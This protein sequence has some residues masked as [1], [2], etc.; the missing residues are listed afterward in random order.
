MNTKYF[1]VPVVVENEGVLIPVSGYKRQ[2]KVSIRSSSDNIAKISE[3]DITAVVRTAKYTKAGEY[4]VPVEIDLSPEL[5][6]LD[7]LEVKVFPDTLV[8]S[9]DEKTV[10]FITVHPSL[11]GE[12]PH[13]YEVESVKVVPPTVEV[14]G[15]KSLL[16]NV[17][18]MLTD[19]ILLNDHVVSFVKKASLI[20]LNS[21]LETD[22]DVSVAVSVSIRPVSLTKKYD[23]IAIS[24]TSLKPHFRIVSP[25]ETVSF[26]LSGSQLALENLAVDDYTVQADCSMINTVGTYEI[27]LLYLVP[28]TLTLS[29]KSKDKITVTVEEVTSKSEAEVDAGNADR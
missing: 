21:F 13:G 4:N 24:Y 11:S 8:M 25:K 3:K 6:L 29:D 23:N 16:D 26:V 19:E 22:D 2:V 10:S 5:L 1:A 9:L 18:E 28:S 12:I 27:P 15:P 14:S 7:P 17:S 20:N